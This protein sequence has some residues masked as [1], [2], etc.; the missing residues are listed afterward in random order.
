MET[1]TREDSR[2]GKNTFVGGCFWLVGGRAASPKVGVVLFERLLA[3]NGREEEL[4][5]EV[6]DRLPQTRFQRHL[7]H[8]ES[9]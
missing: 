1:I 7:R 6:V 2:V 9:Q 8:T 5:A 4:V 3:G